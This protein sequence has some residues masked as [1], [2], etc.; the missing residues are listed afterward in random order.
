MYSF[1]IVLSNLL[2]LCEMLPVG[3]LHHSYQQQETIA[4]SFTLDNNFGH[5]KESALARGF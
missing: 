1:R 4:V 2:K 3:K 5:L